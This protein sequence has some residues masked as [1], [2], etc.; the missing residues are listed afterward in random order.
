MGE[1]VRIEDVA[2][3]LVAQCE[4]SIEIVHTGLRPGEKLHEI[5]L[6][7]DEQDNRRV[8]PLISHVD[9][10]VLLPEDF[11]VDLTSDSL[12]SLTVQ[13]STLSERTTGQPAPLPR[14]QG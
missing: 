12:E 5:L 1:P 2:R 10:P 6:G 7:Q 11:V 9:V 14:S 8:H 4:R 3:Q 13:L